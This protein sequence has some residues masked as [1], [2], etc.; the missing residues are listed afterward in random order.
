MFEAIHGSAPRRANQNLAN[1][2]GL[3]LAGVMMMVHIGQPEIAERVHNAWLRT[4]EDGIHTY[5]IFREGVSKQK[6][7]TKEFGQAIVERLGQEPQ[8]LKPVTYAKGDNKPLEVKITPTVIGK[9]E[10]VGVDVF[11]HWNKANKNP[12]VLGDEIVRKVNVEGAKLTM[13]SN[14]GQKVYPGGSP[15]TFC[16]DNWRCRYMAT[17][18]TLSHA[19][20]I[21]LLQAVEDAGFDFIKIETLC[22]FDGE[23]AFSMGQGE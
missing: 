10:M 4:L 19:H 22:T 11:L 6:V 14:R 7:G 3:L 23:K 8:S 12:N 21:A 18:G 17:N 13:I 20:I 2:S 1:P 9:K 16:V 5:D 15:E